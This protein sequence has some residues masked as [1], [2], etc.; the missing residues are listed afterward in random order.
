MEIRSS[1]DTVEDAGLEPLL[2]LL[3]IG[4]P[5][6]NKDYGNNEVKLFFVI[7]CLPFEANLRKR[8]DKKE[9][10]LYWD[11]LLDYEEVKSA[12]IEQKK[13]MLANSVI[14]SFDILDKYKKLNLDKQKIQQEA[15]EYFRELG[16]I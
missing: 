2:N 5:F 11:I 1:G 12:P 16:W 13:V 14:A 4:R 3:N 6:H 9:K 10:V 7:N 8:F 15:K